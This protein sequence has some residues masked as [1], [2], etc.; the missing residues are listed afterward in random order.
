MQYASKD[1]LTFALVA[2]L[3]SSCASSGNAHRSAAMHTGYAYAFVATKAER[4]QD[5]NYYKA[6]RKWAQARKH[7][8]RG[9]ENGLAGLERR[10]PGFAA[11]LKENPGQAVAQTNSDDVPLLYW[12]AAS[13]G[14]AIGTS[15]DKPEWIIRLPQVGTLA[16]RVTELQP[17]YSGGAAFQLLM[18]YEAS[19]PAMMGGSITLAKHYYEKAL[20][21]SGDQNA[22]LFVAYGETISVQEQDRETFIAMMNRALGIKGGGALNRIARKRA[23]WLLGRI[24]DLFI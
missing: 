10:Y 6:Q 17:D 18:I 7:Y 8:V 15:K 3:G 14:A 1:L 12:T 11:A 5:G 16:F 20:Q 2:L 22:G 21:Y 9:Y 24:D 4:L 13:L 23:K 19:R